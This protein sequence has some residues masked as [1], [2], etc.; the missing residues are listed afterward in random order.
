M[1]ID[2]GSWSASKAMNARTPSFSAPRYFRHE[3]STRE[4]SAMNHANFEIG[5]H[6]DAERRP[7]FVVDCKIVGTVDE[8]KTLIAAYERRAPEDLVALIDER[9]VY[10]FCLHSDAQRTATIHERP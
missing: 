1:Q 7:L 8:V 9:I 2:P 10:H 4:D 5:R 3:P 6:F